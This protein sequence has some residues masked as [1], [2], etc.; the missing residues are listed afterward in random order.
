MILACGAALIAAT[1][2]LTACDTKRRQTE[3]TS[4]AATDWAAITAVSPTEAMGSLCLLCRHAD[5]TAKGAAA[6]M[7]LTFSPKGVEIPGGE[8]VAIS[9]AAWKGMVNMVNASKGPAAARA[10]PGKAHNY[11]DGL[12]K[13]KRHA[14]TVTSPDAETL[15]LTVVKPL[16]DDSEG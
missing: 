8:N 15:V 3:G 10:M 1:A 7:T 2:A 13:A 11:A 9:A 14:Y 12:G 4:S 16:E 6:P 5:L